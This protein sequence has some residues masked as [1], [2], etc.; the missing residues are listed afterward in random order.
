VDILP[1]VVVTWLFAIG[2]WGIAT[3]RNSIALVNCLFVVQSSGY[4]LLLTIGYRTRGTAAI[5]AQLPEKANVVDPVVQALV[6]T[7]VVVGA[8]VSALLLV[9][10]VQ[11]HKTAGT[12]DPN[13][14]R[15]RQEKG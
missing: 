9:F 7:D 13:D 1:Y 5:M 14:S 6:L 12:S 2:L 3:S 10:A 8:T 15:S 4:V 11:V